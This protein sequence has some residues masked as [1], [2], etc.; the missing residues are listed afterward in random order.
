M[1]RIKDTTEQLHIPELEV[2]LHNHYLPNSLKHL[3]SH[4]FLKQ[5]HRYIILS[6]V[7]SISAI[8]ENILPGQGESVKYP[9]DIT[10]NKSVVHIS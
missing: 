9:R 4:G 10:K 8:K 5:T 3:G 1:T 7:S 2:G 6:R